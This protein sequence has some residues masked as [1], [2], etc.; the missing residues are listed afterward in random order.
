VPSF[1]D[2][3]ATITTRLRI[4][5]VEDEEGVRDFLRALLSREGYRVTLAGGH[6]EALELAESTSFDLVVTDVNMPD[7]SGPDLIRTLR[8]RTPGLPAV[9]ISG[10]S[11]DEFEM[12]APGEGRN[13]IQK[14][15]EGARLVGRIEAMLER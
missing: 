10:I 14:P 9:F 3:F 8:R 11:R 1:P 4:L 2:A 7:G 5:A 12:M 15:F 6:D 13:F